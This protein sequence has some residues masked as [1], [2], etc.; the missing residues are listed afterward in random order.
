MYIMCDTVDIHDLT[1]Q[2]DINFSPDKGNTWTITPEQ[3]GWVLSHN[4]I[5]GEINA[6][7]ETLAGL[8]RQL[9]GWEI[10][11]LK[12]WWEGHRI[13][14]HEH[15]NNE[16]NIFNPFLRTRI[17]Y[18]E[19]L[20]TD[21]QGIIKIMEQINT[22]IFTLTPGDQTCEIKILW[23]QYRTLMFPHLEEEE[24]VGLPLAMAYFTQK[25]VSEKT[26]QFI[27]NG[28]KR[29]LGSFIHW[30]GD[31]ARCQQFQKSEGIPWFVWYLPKDGF[32]ALRSH[33]RKTMVSHLDSLKAGKI[34][35]SLHRKK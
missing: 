3:S 25:E 18:P 23:D 15:H 34:V 33:Y 20:E 16:D 21:H 17:N 9:R 14:V 12:L 30:L 24:Q 31:K 5:R 4:A 2:A 19:K 26:A 27:K 13:H 10:K 7:R 28:D 35:S 32:K 8:K 22:V 29:S 1:Y 11:C 6:M